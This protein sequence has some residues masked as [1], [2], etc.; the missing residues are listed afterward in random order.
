MMIPD[1]KPQEDPSS[2]EGATVVRKVDVA[3]LAKEATVNK[4][5]AVAKQ[6]SLVSIREGRYLVVAMTGQ[7]A[8][9]DG[10]SVDE[11]GITPDRARNKVM[12]LFGENIYLESSLWEQ[13]LLHADS[14]TKVV[15]EVGDTPLVS[16]D[17]NVDGK[18]PIRIRRK[19]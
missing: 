14:G 16:P 9:A 8:G 5:R 10:D 13:A 7:F 1:E 17:S 3:R 4:Q 2:P 6:V 12:N 19:V 18:L 15:L 11:E